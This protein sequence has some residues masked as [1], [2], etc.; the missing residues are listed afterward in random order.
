MKEYQCESV[1]LHHAYFQYTYFEINHNN[2]K[3]CKNNHGIA[4]R[5]VV[6]AGTSHIPAYADRGK[7]EVY[8]TTGMPEPQTTRPFAMATCGN[9]NCRSE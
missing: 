5:T 2:A 9:Y 6:D 7:M 3:L 8:F 4:T 1:F